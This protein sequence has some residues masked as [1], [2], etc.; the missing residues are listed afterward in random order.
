MHTCNLDPFA[1]ESGRIPYSD[2]KFKYYVFTN[3]FVTTTYHLNRMALMLFYSVRAR[4]TFSDLFT[5]Y[6]ED[7]KIHAAWKVASMKK[8]SPF[9]FRSVACASV[10]VTFFE[11]FIIRC[12]DSF[13]RTLIIRVGLGKQL[14]YPA[15]L[16]SAT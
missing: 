14:L 11:R 2:F 15:L 7:G 9:E 6:L 10:V 12:M 13:L 4:I 1:A 16:S 5:E 8:S 3:N